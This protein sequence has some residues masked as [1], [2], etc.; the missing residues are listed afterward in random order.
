MWMSLPTFCFLAHL[1]PLLGFVLMSLN[2]G[3]HLYFGEG[4]AVIHLSLL[5]PRS[6]LIWFLFNNRYLKQQAPLFTLISLLLR[7]ESSLM[8]LAI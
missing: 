2:T 6:L 8:S 5:G 7:L 4:V 3:H 1:C